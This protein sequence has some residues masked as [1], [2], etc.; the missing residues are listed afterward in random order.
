MH[1]AAVRR[2]TGNQLSHRLL[3]VWEFRDGRISRENVWI[4]SGSA[5]AQLTASA[6]FA[7]GA[8]HT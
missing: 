2:L 8:A 5:I 6:D 7:S 3:R 4:D 1:S